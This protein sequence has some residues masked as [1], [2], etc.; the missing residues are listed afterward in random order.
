AP[1]SALAAAFVAPT[2]PAGAV[3]KI[4][5]AAPACTD[6]PTEI[7]LQAK[8]E[9]PRPLQTVDPVVPPDVTLSAPTSVRVQ[10]LIDFD[11]ASRYPA[12]VG[13]PPNLA[14]AAVAA[15][16]RWRWEPPRVNGAPVLTPTVVAIVFKP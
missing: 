6:T 16:R 3:I 10:I 11:G 8:S 12:Y 15:A 14:D 1:A 5:Y 9:G 2:I 7:A 4:R 13:G